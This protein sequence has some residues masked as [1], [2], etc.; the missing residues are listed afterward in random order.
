MRTKHVLSISE[1]R[2][3]IFDIADE[4]QKPGI[5]YTFTEKGKPKT[6]MMSYDEFDSLMETL[7]IM[8]DPKIMKN[9][10]KAEEE[11]RKGNYVT[12]EELEKELGYVSG[13]M[14]LA[15]KGKKKY[16]VRK[17]RSKR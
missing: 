11:A 16:E 1:A 6:V 15:D 10:E 13:A 4:V 3:K 8:S 5:H 14:V 9:I 2:K 17:I 12:L 7:E